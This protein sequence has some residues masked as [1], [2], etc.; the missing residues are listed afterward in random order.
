MI[1]TYNSNDTCNTWMC[2]QKQKICAFGDSLMVQ[3]KTGETDFPNYPCYFFFVRFWKLFF[4]RH[5]FSMVGI[6]YL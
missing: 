5:F 6:L 2:W 4:V 1:S 3:I